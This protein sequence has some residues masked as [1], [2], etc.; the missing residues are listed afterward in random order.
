MIYSPSMEDNYG[1]DVFPSLTDAILNYKKNQNPHSLVDEVK[2]Q[3]SILI[4]T[5]QSASSVLKEPL[6]FHRYVY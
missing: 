3:L 6:N 4:A 5:I 1:N 2:F